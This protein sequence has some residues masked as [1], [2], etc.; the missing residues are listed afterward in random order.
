MYQTLVFQGIIFGGVRHRNVVGTEQ[1]PMPET[2]GH[3]SEVVVVHFIGLLETTSRRNIVMRNGQTDNRTIRQREGL[4][5]QAFPERTA[6]DHQ[7][8]VPILNRSD[9]NFARRNGLFINQYNHPAVLEQSGRC[10]LL[11]NPSSLYRVGIRPA[12]CS[13]SI[14]WSSTPVAA[15][16]K[17]PG[18][19]AHR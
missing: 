10:R 13:P 2:L 14:K 18:L 5:C 9:Q 1:L 17:P 3:I 16:M 8:P 6:S 12:F 19:P 7:S 15:P 4:L 11:Y